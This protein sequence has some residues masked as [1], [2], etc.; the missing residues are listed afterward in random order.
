MTHTYEEEGAVVL[1]DRGGTSAAVDGEP[2]SDL[3]V[4]VRA[5]MLAGRVAHGINKLTAHKWESVLAD[6]EP[7][8]PSRCRKLGASKACCTACLCVL[9]KRVVESCRHAHLECPFTTRTLAL[10]YRTAMQISATNLDARQEALSL[11]DT[12]LVAK[13]KLLG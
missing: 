4:Q 2:G 7:L 13:Y 6:A 5:R 8:G 12:A 9:G 1:D 11:S 10:V 3:V